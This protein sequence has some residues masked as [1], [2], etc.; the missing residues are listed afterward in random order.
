[1]M[2]E[3]HLFVLRGLARRIGMNL[4]RAS[5][6]ENAGGSTRERWGVHDYQTSHHLTEHLCVGK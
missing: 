4:L 2:I 1:M 6:R 5:E 3:L